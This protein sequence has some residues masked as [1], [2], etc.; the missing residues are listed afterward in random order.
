M[1]AFSTNSNSVSTIESGASSIS[2]TVIVT[3]WL[4]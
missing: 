4:L 2:D 1:K 3:S